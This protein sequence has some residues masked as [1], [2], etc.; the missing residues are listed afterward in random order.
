MHLSTVL[1]CALTVSVAAAQYK[2]FNY[3]STLTDGS[4]KTQA[5]F[6]AEFAAAKALP[7]TSGFTSARLYTTI[8]GGTTNTPILAIPAAIAQNTTI[9]LGMWASGGQAD[10]TNEIAALTA[11]ITQYGSS[12]TDLV[13]GI[14]VGS[15]DL[16]RDSATGQAADAG[17]GIG[18][19]LLVQYIKQVK[20]AVASTTLSSAKITHVDTYNA[21]TNGSN[22]AVI[23]AVDFL[24][25]D[26]YPYFQKEMA[27]SIEYGAS[28]F[29][30]A[31]QETVAVA[32]GKDVWVSETG[33]P[34]SGPTEGSGVASVANAQTFWDAVGC[35]LLFGKVNTYWYILQDALPTLP[36]PSFGI[37][38][39]GSVSQTP[40]FN[41]TCPASGSS[42][43][44]VA[45]AGSAS[46]SSSV[47]SSAAGARSSSSTSSS[48]SASRGAAVA[49]V[50]AA[51][52]A[53]SVASARPAVVTSAVAVSNA[54]SST[55]ASVA[56]A[57]PAKS[58]STTVKVSSTSAKTTSSS[59]GAK[60]SS[61]AA[62]ASGAAV[63]ISTSD[64][65]IVRAGSTIVGL[66]VLLAGI[67]TL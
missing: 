4:A 6:E 1:S 61:T 40:L 50:G 55:R 41:L 63:P 30:T 21:W 29:Q 16:Y 3:G 52:A 7:G 18:P 8:Q 12:F 22:S 5:D 38:G 62:S 33:W 26:V 14:S 17:V 13:V 32:A 51:A 43:S 57:V 11:A 23:A 27:N 42:P 54:T 64:S 59:N 48:A 47:T 36:S 39:A 37:V 28:L 9:F 65:E 66:F 58:G 24:S 10:M 49:A 44:A 67:M 20:T 35:D 34:V 15:E 31:Y 56:S 45:L 19:D 60:A 25:M 46:S 53:S 2:G